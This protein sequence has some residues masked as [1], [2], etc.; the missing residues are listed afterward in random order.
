MFTNDVVKETICN[1]YFKVMILM[2]LLCF[3]NITL[4]VCED[5]DYYYIINKKV[6]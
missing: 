4:M 6:S 1:N 2:I 3:K 5:E